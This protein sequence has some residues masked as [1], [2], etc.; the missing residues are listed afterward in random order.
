MT[1]PLYFLVFYLV[2]NFG[3]RRLFILIGSLLLVELLLTTTAQ[4]LADFYGGS[5]HGDILAYPFSFKWIIPGL[6]ILGQI[7]QMTSWSLGLST[8][9]TILATDL[10]PH[11]IRALVTQVNLNFLTYI[12][13]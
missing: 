11:G 2:E 12:L 13:I 8:M 7:V 3:R 9:T 1:W 5:L 6:A 10:C 4:F